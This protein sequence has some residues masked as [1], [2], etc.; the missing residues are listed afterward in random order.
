MRTTADQLR[1]VLD[2][3]QTGTGPLYQQLADAMVSLAESGSLDHGTRLPSERAL[4]QAL[5]LSRN[6][7]TAAYQR[8][9]DDA[10]LDGRPGAAPTLGS[11]ARGLDAMSLHDRFAKILPGS[12]AP[13]VGLSSACPPPAPSVVEAFAD[14]RAVLDAS[15]TLGTGYA[16]LGD[17]DLVDVIVERLRAAGI[18]AHPDEVVVTSGGQQAL[19]L[20][21]TEMASP[22][23]PVA[24]ESVTYPGVFDA[25]SSSGS[26][27]LSLPMGPDGLDVESAI[28]LLRAARPD[29]A[30]F[31]T[32]HNPTGTVMSTADALAI[33]ECAAATG[34][35]LVDDRITATLTLNGSPAPPLA[36]LG[37]GASVITISGLS[38]VFWGGLR[39][40]WLHTNATLAAQLRQRKAAMDL[41]SSAFMQRVA[42]ELMTDS[43]DETLAW[44]IGSLRESL[45][46]TVEAIRE[47]APDWRFRMPDGG[48]S[49][50]VEVPGIN[51]DR[52]AARAADAGVPVA[53]GTAFEV[54]PGGGASHF[55]LPFYLPPDDMRLGVKVL[56]GLAP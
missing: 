25:I 20:A 24:L 46:A 55:R 44:R 53:P 33:A 14:P 37:T 15:P 4:A 12:Q 19:W 40:G 9:R 38:K 5:H 8:L 11:R 50:W 17:P 10:W 34:T 48:P 3:W 22:G 45:D 42:R 39:I 21:L 47:F 51:A 2:H 23:T 27:P 52:F 1:D 49:L 29:V 30:Y 6:T 26:R 28:K 43:Y 36:S 16:A 35:T 32:F 18:P 31:T 41:G 54:A 56:A 13:L 7:V